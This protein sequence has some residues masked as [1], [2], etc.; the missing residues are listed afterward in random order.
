M[1]MGKKLMTIFFLALLQTPSFLVQTLSLCRKSVVL[2]LSLN[3]FGWN[4]S[5]FLSFFVFILFI[6]PTWS[7]M[8]EFTYGKHVQDEKYN[9]Q[10]LLL[11][12]CKNNGKGERAEREWVRKGFVCTGKKGMFNVEIPS[13]PHHKCYMRE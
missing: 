8:S 13:N 6:F 10:L 2:F 7:F 9:S 4:F 11:F 1:E 12:F 3:R 5:S